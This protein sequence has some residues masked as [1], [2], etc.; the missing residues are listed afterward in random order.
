MTLHEKLEAKRRQNIVRLQE[1]A[2]CHIC[3]CS[4][5][6]RCFFNFIPYHG[7]QFKEGDNKEQVMLNSSELEDSG[8]QPGEPMQMRTCR[9]F[10]VEEDNDCLPYS[11]RVCEMCMKDDAVTGRI[12]CCGLCGIVACDEDCGAWEMVECMD[13][14][15]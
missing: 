4:S 1:A 3:E 7:Q 6:R 2:C 14:E 13:H 8:S 15:E 10:G 5:G 9:C 11:L 12:R